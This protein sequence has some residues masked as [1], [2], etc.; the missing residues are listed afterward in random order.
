V[1]DLYFSE[2]ANA[3]LEELK[4]TPSRQHLLGRINTA[5]DMLETDPHDVRCRRR[6]FNTIGCWAI[7]VISDEGDWLILWSERN[8]RDTEVNIHAITPD[9]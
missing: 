5:L 4:G 8:E 1:T 9:P 7:T 3:L 2:Q 6:R